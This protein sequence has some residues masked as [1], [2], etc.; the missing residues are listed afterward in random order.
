MSLVIAK[1]GK[2]AEEELVVDAPVPTARWLGMRM[3]PINERRLENFRRN[4]R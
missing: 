1:A 3:T 2:T 4:R